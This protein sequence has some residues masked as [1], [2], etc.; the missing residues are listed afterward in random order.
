MPI[1]LAWIR[2]EP[3]GIYLPPADA[4]IDP[5]HAVPRALVTHGH[6]D[7]ARGGHG[8]TVATAATLAIMGLRYGV[9]PEGAQAVDYGE[10]IAL[11]GG[12]RATFV[13]AG[14]VL[15]SAQILLERD[16][17]RVVVTGDY[18]RSPD[19]TC[20]PFEP[21]PCDVF[22][23]EATFGLPVFRHPPIAEEIARLRETQAANPQRCVLVGAYALGKAQRLIA[24]LRQ[25]GHDAPIFLHGAMERMCTLYREW[26]IDLGELRP[27]AGVAKAELAG[28]IVVCPPSALNDRWSRRLPDP[29]TAMASG[30]M[31]VRQRARQRN[32]E[33]PLVISDHADWD[34][35]TTTIAEVNPAET[36][37]T[38][39]REE[40]LLRWCALHQRKARALAM[41]GYEDEDD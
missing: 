20:A 8:Q 29:I 23:T 41:V 1:D 38:H 19:P 18:K 34:E 22:I 17:Q 36:W 16:G 11:P 14:H 10:S 28:H 32:V 40:A 25:A 30:W 37:I 39:G 12:I 31:R 2:P 5:A 21:V 24:E 4:W 7:H 13:P 35:L 33:L 27:A 15:G 6:S 9:M 26:G 3:Q